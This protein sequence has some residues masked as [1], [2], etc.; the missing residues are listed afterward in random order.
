MKNIMKNK[1]ACPETDIKSST[2]TSLIHPKSEEKSSYSRNE[3]GS[4]S[5]Y[6]FINGKKGFP[7][8]CVC[9][10]DVTIYTSA[11]KTNPGRLYFRCAVS[12]ENGHLF[13]WVEDGIYEEVIDLLERESE[14][15]KGIMGVNELKFEMENVKDQVIQCKTELRRFKI[16]TWYS[17]FVFVFWLL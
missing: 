16:T 4:S 15:E 13:K 2:K 11:S 12:R 8:Q 1:N 5:K 7:K 9:G 10:S 17:L 14:N 6:G 3:F